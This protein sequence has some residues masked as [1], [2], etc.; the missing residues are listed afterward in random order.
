M[1]PELA[2]SMAGHMSP[3][4]RRGH[5]Q[6]EP[7]RERVFQATCPEETMEQATH[8]LCEVALGKYEVGSC[9]PDLR[10]PCTER[11]TRSCRGENRQF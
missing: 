11:A 2:V 3:S 7:F 4:T 5:E 1:L 8:V 6:C 9:I 10:R